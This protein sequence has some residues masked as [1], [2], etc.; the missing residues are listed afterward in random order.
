MFKLKIYLYVWVKCEEQN[1]W[2]S[3]SEQEK[4]AKHYQGPHKLDA[5]SSHT[6]WIQDRLSNADMHYDISDEQKQQVLS[7]YRQH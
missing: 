5:P 7:R 4:G 3:G 1:L 2:L 6:E